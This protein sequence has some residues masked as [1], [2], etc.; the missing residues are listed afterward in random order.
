MDFS[1]V[2]MYS[3]DIME[4]KWLVLCAALFMYLLV[5][6]FQDKK[7]VFSSAAAIILLVLGIIFPG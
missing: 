2:F 4:M 1:E 7:V 6:L 5:I 3:A